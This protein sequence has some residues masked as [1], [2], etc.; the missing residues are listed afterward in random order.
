MAEFA[1]VLSLLTQDKID[2]A[3]L[4]A[5]KYA[6][7]YPASPM[8]LNLLGLV[9]VKAKQ[10]DEARKT[11][12]K[13][14][15]MA[16]GEPGASQNLA[17]LALEEGDTDTAIALYQGI[18]KFHPNQGRTVIR[19]ASLYQRLGRF[20]ELEP[21]LEDLVKRQPD[22]FDA[23]VLLSSIY[24]QQ[25]KPSQAIE[26]LSNVPEEKQNH[27]AT[28]DALGD[29]QLANGETQNAIN[30][31]E[32]LV[33]AQPLSISA[34][35]KLAQAYYRAGN[36]KRL[37]ETLQ[38][39]LK[40]NPEHVPSQI[41]MISLRILQNRPEEAHK[42]LAKLE[43]EFPGQP[44]IL[45]QKARLAQLENKPEEAVHAY[46]QA[47]SARPSS[48]LVQQLALARWQAG[49]QDASIKTLEGWLKSSPDDT[50][51]AYNLGLLYFKLDRRDD[52]RRTFVAVLDNAP[53]HVQALNNLALLMRDDQPEAARGYAERALQ[54]S[55][56]STTLQ[57][58]LAMT[59]ISQG[60]YTQ[61]IKLLDQ[62]SQLAPANSL[63]SYHL[64][65]ALHKAGQ[66]ARA[67]RVLNKV[68]ENDLSLDEKV[69]VEKLLK[70]LEGA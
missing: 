17:A 10:I 50:S 44:D 54:I 7:K 25:G 34:Y 40:L 19:L 36:V 62:A 28:L 65:L 52:A 18:L 68:L 27:P 8:V 69:E 53:N 1:L 11:F 43:Q 31:F 6:D 61:A 39:A 20:R 37:E 67:R 45:I 38:A 15:E 2:E 32:L 49:Q 16:P 26:I 58:T 42:L 56:N 35:Y 70:E 41:S 60:D 9:Q 3:M 59:L 66:D 29:A 22:T 55:P 63:I 5:K 23:R 51:V 64:A 48:E 30:N 21:L 4:E 24:L 33:K 46:Q 13:V 57:D 12:Q 14:L 47:L